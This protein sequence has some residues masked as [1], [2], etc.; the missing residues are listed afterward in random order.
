MTRIWMDLT[1]HNQALRSLGD[2]WTRGSTNVDIW[3]PSVLKEVTPALF[4]GWNVGH[5]SIA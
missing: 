2:L 4:T 3:T 5:K 1:A